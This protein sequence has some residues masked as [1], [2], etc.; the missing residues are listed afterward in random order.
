MLS[1]PS[2][3]V[4]THQYSLFQQLRR[5]S[6]LPP[7]SFIALQSFFTASPILSISVNSVHTFKEPST[8]LAHATVK[9]E[10][11]KLSLHVRFK[12]PGA[13]LAGDA[14]GAEKPAGWLECS[15]GTVSRK[16]RPGAESFKEH[17]GMNLE[18]P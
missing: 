11:S 8:P 9:T 6:F 16:A 4:G 18:I 3:P 15:E 13:H 5:R 2:V 12:M 1:G 17:E 14:Q 7:A 10:K